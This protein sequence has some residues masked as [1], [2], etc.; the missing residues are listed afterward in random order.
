MPQWGSAR[1][2]AAPRA[3]TVG[4]RSQSIAAT[5]TIGAQHAHQVD[6]VLRPALTAIVDRTL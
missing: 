3:A 6:A 5:K 1:S 2:A 4:P